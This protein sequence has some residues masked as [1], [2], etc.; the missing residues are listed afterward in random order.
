MFALCFKWILKI[1]RYWSENIIFKPEEHYLNEF[2]TRKWS[3]Q[4]PTNKFERIVKRI[5]SILFLFGWRN[6]FLL[7]FN[8]CEREIIPDQEAWILIFMFLI[9]SNKKSEKS[10]KLK[11]I[12][13]DEKKNAIHDQFKSI[14]RKNHRHLKHKRK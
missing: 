6:F 12:W 5:L 3:I 8:V 1:N 11:G 7:G 4:Y 14:R 10:S 13:F 9:N 2:P